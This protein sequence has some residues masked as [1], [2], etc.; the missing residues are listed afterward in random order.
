M[1]I[2]FIIGI[3][4]YARAEL[5]DCFISIELNTRATYVNTKPEIDVIKDSI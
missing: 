1:I 2:A 3:L 4:V 5:I